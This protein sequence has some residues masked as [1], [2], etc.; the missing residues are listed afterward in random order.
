MLTSFEQTLF[1]SVGL[2]DATVLLSI[3]ATE[4]SSL[5]HGSANGIVFEMLFVRG[6]LYFATSDGFVRFKSMELGKLEYLRSG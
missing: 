4:Y 2:L 3:L 6:R 1:K 5:M